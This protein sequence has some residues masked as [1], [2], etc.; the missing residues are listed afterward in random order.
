[1]GQGG[2]VGGTADPSDRKTAQ[3][4]ILALT[5][6]PLTPADVGAWADLLAAAED[7]DQTGENY[8]A[9]DLAEELADPVLDAE[10]DSLALWQGTRMVGYAVVRCRPNAR[11]TDRVRLEGVVHPDWRG[12]GLGR[13]L[14][15]WACARGAHAHRE[16]NPDV[17]G[18]LAHG[19]MSTH[20]RFRSLL[21]QVGFTPARYFFDMERRLSEPIPPAE[22]P[23]RLR[24]VRFDRAYEERL[25]AAHN[26]AFADHWSFEPRDRAFWRTW[27]T[28]SRNFRARTSFLLLHADEIVAYCLA[29]EYEA[30][31]DATGVRDCYL[32]QV[33]TRPDWRKRGAA[34]AL[35]IR[36]LNAAKAAGYDRASLSVDTENLTGALGLYER[37]GFAVIRQWIS[38]ARPLD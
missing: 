28:G 23:E 7:V 19:A 37:L 36:S 25:V 31:T 9:E 12:R 18:C 4:G 34:R 13:E 16:F 3:E 10:R 22:V 1:M 32:G 38:Y 21:E 8:G 17:P 6:R 33:G 30:D 27:M 14:L 11:E 24:L 5:R 26:L 2:A 15:D 35:I 20:A 29:Y